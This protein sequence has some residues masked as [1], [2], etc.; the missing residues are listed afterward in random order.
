MTGCGWQVCIISNRKRNGY[1]FEKLNTVGT[2]FR[3]PGAFYAYDIIKN[4]NINST[5]KVTYRDENC[6]LKSYIVQ[7]INT[8]VFKDPEAIMENIDRV[9]SHIRAAYPN[10]ISLHF[11]HTDD[12]KNYLYDEDGS[13]W[14]V[15]NYVDSITFDTCDDLGV[16]SATGEAFGRFQNQLADFDGSLLHETIPDFHNTHKRLDKLFDDVAANPVNRNADAEKEIEYISSVRLEAGKLSEQYSN[17]SFPCRVTHNDTKSNNVLFDRITKRPLVVIDLDTVMPGMSVYD[18]GDAVRFICNTAAEDEPDVRRVYFDT[19]KFRAFCHGYL[20]A[21]GRS[22]TEVEK[23]S[24]VLGAFSI[25][26]ELASR[27]LDDYLTGDTY[28][29]VN[30]PGHNLVRTRCQLALAKDIQRKKDELEWIVEET[31]N[32]D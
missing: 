12:G 10:E 9:T 4:G 3:L 11:H 14:R 17:G 32:N 16:I 18:F 28:F 2:S 30:Y 23:K 27:F 1:M 8:N 21:V 15:M 25:T 20:G 31:L 24:L 5:Y 7:K 13:F 19:S 22:L 6:H 26:I 29:K